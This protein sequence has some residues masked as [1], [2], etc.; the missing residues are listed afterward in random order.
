MI[1]LVVA[2]VALMIFVNAM[3]VAAEFGTVSARAS[4]VAERAEAG[5]PTARRLLPFLQDRVLMDRYIAACQVGITL[6]SLLVGYYGQAQ[7]TPHVAPLLA[8]IGLSEAA[9]A[10]TAVIALLLSLTFLQVLFGEIVPK[11]IALRFPEAMALALVHPMRWSLVVL[12]PLIALLNGSAL[13]LLKRF[14][15][16]TPTESHVHHPDELEAI[17]AQSAEGGLIDADEREMLSRVFHLNQRIVRQIMVPR[18]RMVAVPIDAD[19]QRLVR[20]LVGSTHT[21]FPV[22]EGR[23][24]HV[25]GIVHLRDLYAATRSGEPTELRTIVRP[26]PILPETLSVADAWDRMRGEHV[27]MAAIFDEHGGVVGIVTVEDILEEVFGE[28]QDEFDEEQELYREGPEGEITLRGDMLVSDVNER[29]LLDLPEASVD[30][31]GG[32]VMD[33]L[34]RVPDEGDEAEADRVR[35]TVLAVEG[36]AVERVR[37]TPLAPDVDASD[38]DEAV[39]D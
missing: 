16:G 38:G 1:A 12:R 28:F 7:L 11:S 37:L 39:D 23:I 19:P 32:L 14:G 9:A 27:T 8:R 18:N 3:Y 6:S 21:R 2:V 10:S 33:L 29:F 30:T 25:R 20:E 26:A 35:L 24:D 36:Q 17:F 34:Q 13:F 22:Y 4:R 31:I 5:H 15:R